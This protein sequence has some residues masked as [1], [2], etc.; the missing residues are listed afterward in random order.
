M[1]DALTGTITTVMVDFSDRLARISKQ[2]D[3]AR[4]AELVLQDKI[5]FSMSLEQWQEYLKLFPEEVIQ[6]V[7]GL[8]QQ[9]L[10]GELLLVEVL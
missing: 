8:Q 1:P 5:A 10:P 7:A 2:G 6:H 4:Q 3:A 9:R